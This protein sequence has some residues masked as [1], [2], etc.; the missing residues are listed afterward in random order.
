M[1]PE[2]VPHD[3]GGGLDPDGAGHDDVDRLLSEVEPADAACSGQGHLAGG[4][5]DRRERRFVSRSGGFEQHGDEL[6]IR[7]G[8]GSRRLDDCLDVPFLVVQAEQPHDRIGH[9]GRLAEPE[10]GVV[11]DAQ[12]PARQVIAAC[13]VAGQLAA[14]AA[15]LQPPAGRRD[16]SG[17]GARP[18]DGADAAA[19]FAAGLHPEE[20]VVVHREACEAELPDDPVQA[21]FLG[22]DI[23]SG[24]AEGGCRSILC[25][26]PVAR[27]EQA[28]LF[29][30]DPLGADV[31]VLELLVAAGA[32]A[33]GV[34]LPAVQIEQI[35][36]GL[37]VAA[38][39]ADD[40]C[41]LHVMILPGALCEL[42]EIFPVSFLQLVEAGAGRVVIADERVHHEGAHGRFLAAGHGCRHRL[43]LVG[44]DH[45]HIIA[46]M[47]VVQIR[48]MNRLCSVLADDGGDFHRVAV[49]HEAESA[50]VQQ[51]DDMNLLLVVPD[52]VHKA[53]G[54]LGVVRP[55]AG[56]QQ[57]RLRMKL[58]V[59]IHAEQVLL[60]LHAAFSARLPAFHEYLQLFVFEIVIFQ[61]RR[62]N[63]AD[64][65]HE[66]LAEAAGRDVLHRLAVEA[67]VER[68]LQVVLAV[69]LDGRDP[70]QMV[71]AD[72]GEAGVGQLHRSADA[73]EH[74][75][76]NVAEAEHLH[77][78]MGEDGFGQ[79]AGRVGEVDQP[80]IRAQL[81]HAP[82]DVEHDRNRAHRLEEA[83]DAARFLADHAVLQRYALIQ[84]AGR[85]LA[86]ADLAEHEVRS[87]QR[88]VQIRS[89]HDAAIHA[90]RFDHAA[91]ESPDD[92]ELPL[93]DVHQR[94]LAER[95][96]FLALDDA[97]DQFGRVRAAGSDNGDFHP[98]FHLL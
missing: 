3:G 61:V 75:V 13:L 29:S 30:H 88:F 78:R 70:A 73:L 4:M 1:V 5:I 19:G 92:A 21:G 40:A 72:I 90:G 43:A 55:A 93:V 48:Q 58:G 77:L 35:I 80:G 9:G 54:H 68:F 27:E 81:L 97:F 87:A 95:Q 59:G 49:F 37:A 41:V 42:R 6:R 24:Q 15:D 69:V 32:G 71:Q 51:V 36:I 64:E 28:E 85:Q 14:D 50:V 86:D 46:D 96:S 60:D 7:Q 39:N 12:R 76:G 62:R 82:G 10:E 65:L 22:G 47:A 83:A 45:A 26:Q 94:E 34:D 56:C 16:A 23:R 18:V 53:D 91:A 89:K 11:D 8:A 31:A 2:P 25:A 20:A 66:L 33:D 17:A 63:G 98:V 57:L 79:D 52:G 38:V 67:D 74:I 84:H 44:L